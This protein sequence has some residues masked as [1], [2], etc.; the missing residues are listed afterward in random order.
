MRLRGG[1]AVCF[2]VLWQQG[3]DF[4]LGVGHGEIGEEETQVGAGFDAVGLGGLDEA[5]EH[6]AGVRTM[7]VRPGRVPTSGLEP[8]AGKMLE[9]RN[10]RYSS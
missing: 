1:E 3:F 8:D 9:W 6:S 10:V 4:C 5:V 2:D 7:W